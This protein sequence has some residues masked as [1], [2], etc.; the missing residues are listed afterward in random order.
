MMSSQFEYYVSAKFLSDGKHGRSGLLHAAFGGKVKVVKHDL[1]FGLDSRRRSW[2]R[3][4]Y[5]GLGI[6]V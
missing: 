6:G 1:Y 5:L 2:L 4:S 3:N